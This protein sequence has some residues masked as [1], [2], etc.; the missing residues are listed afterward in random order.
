MNT[1]RAL[2][3]PPSGPRENA[4]GHVLLVE[5]DRPLRSAYGKILRREGWA[6]TE[7]ENGHAARELLGKGSFDLVIS[8]IGLPD[9]NGIELLRTVRDHDADTPVVLMTGGAKLSTAIQAVEM[10]ALRYLLKPIAKTALCE[11]VEEGARERERRRKAQRAFAVYDVH[12]SQTA[13]HR[14]ESELVERAISELYMVYQPIVRGSTREVVAYEALVRTSEPEIVHPSHLFEAA[15]RTHK[16]GTM[17][18]KIRAQVAG[19]LAE[20]RAQVFVNL[21]PHDLVDPELYETCAPLSLFADRVTL[22]ITEQVS[23]AGVDDVAGRVEALHALG[24]KI[25]VDDLGA[26]HAGLASL[27]TL[28]PDVVKL[29]MSFTRG[30]AQDRLRQKLVRTVAMLCRDIETTF[31]TEGV[32]TAGELETLRWLGCDVFQGWLFARPDESFPDVD[33][34][35]WDRI[36][37]TP[38]CPPVASNDA[39]DVTLHD[40][41]VFRTLPAG[42]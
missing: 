2:P 6:V 27:T 13:V 8:D 30:I 28:R 34:S 31:V 18:R 11:A 37:V 4:R 17:G 40:P 39:D 22:E 5:D 21:H 9:T 1:L 25:A 33:W 38:V 3:P 35:A 23:L 41:P 32:E 24:Y 36:S 29:D 14:R 12:Q 10:G 15:E 16:L 19:A 26:G 42:L 7:A 20:S